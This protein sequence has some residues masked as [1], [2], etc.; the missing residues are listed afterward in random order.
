MSPTLFPD[1]REYNKPSFWS[2]FVLFVVGVGVGFCLG[3]ATCIWE[4]LR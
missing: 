3:H 1:D 4:V 2:W